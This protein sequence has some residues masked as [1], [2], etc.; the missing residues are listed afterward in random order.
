MI[1]RKLLMSC[2]SVI[3]IILFLFI[4]SRSTQA[5]VPT[6]YQKHELRAAWI[7]SVLNIDWPSK[8][9]LPIEKQKQEFIKL[10][11]D[12]KNLG[13]NAV[14]VQIKPTADAF[15]P[16]R[17]GPW[18]EYLTGVQGKDPG[19][20]PLAFMV[21]EAHKKNL[22]FHAWFNPYRITMNHTNLN[23]LIENHPAKQHPDWVVS[24]GGKLYYNPGIP[25]VK[26]FIIEGILEVVQNYDIDAVHMDDYFYPYKVAG[27]EFPD[28]DT[29]EVYNN[30]K[31]TNIGDWRRDNVNQL[32]SGLNTAI[33]QE[34]SYVKFGISPFGVWRNI[35]DDPTGSNTTAGQRNY[36]DLYA[37]TREW[38]QKGYIDYITP[39][40]YWNIG[41]APAAYD[42]LLDWWVKETENK[43]IHLYIGQAAYKINNNSVPAWSNPEEYPR[44]IALNHQFLQIKGS[45]HFSLKDINSNPLGI[46]DRLQKDIYKHPALI[47]PMLWLDHDPPKHPTLKGAIVRDEGIVLGIIDDRN[48]DSAYYAIYR[49]NGKNEVDIQNP[50]NLLTTVR[51]TKPGEIYVD[52][53]AVSGKTYTYVVTALD[54]LHNESIPSSKTTIQAK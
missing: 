54:R 20:D 32:V 45:I 10:L 8:P 51:K 36:D 21:E 38:I 11:D 44:Q 30:G 13:M 15:Y 33:K 49:V 46:K 35:A 48:N 31:F 5:E 52:K 26:N 3:L 39:Q 53:T 2:C 47:P 19:Y 7:A 16:S 29:Y 6:T 24:Y 34:K 12:V 28:R 18:S 22:E 23:Q 27:E 17:Y 50:E 1:F 43:P 42:V 40:I 9:G 14:V 25:E 37:H 4:S 41:F